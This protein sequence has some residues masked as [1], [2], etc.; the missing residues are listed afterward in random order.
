MG[1]AVLIVTTIAALTP[2]STAELLQLPP[3]YKLVGL[4]LLLLPLLLPLPPAPLPLPLPAPLL[5]PLPTCC[6][7]ETASSATALEP[8]ALSGNT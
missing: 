3:L 8:P 6:D 2:A 5:A 4:L 1:F 7:T